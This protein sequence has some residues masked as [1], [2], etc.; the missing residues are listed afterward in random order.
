[1]DFFKNIK[2]FA[3]DSLFHAHAIVGYQNGS[4]CETNTFRRY[5]DIANATGGTVEPLC[6][7]FATALANLGNNAFGLRE[8]FF[9]SRSPVP[10]TIVVRVNN[11]EQT[12]GWSYD[13]NSNSIIFAAAP[14]QNS[15]I[16]VNYKAAC[17]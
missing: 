12:S 10:A 11:V 13:A 17:Y 6:G 7:N 1:M 9:L 2:G 3:N 14:P 8:Q 5:I 16:Q 15:T 4:S